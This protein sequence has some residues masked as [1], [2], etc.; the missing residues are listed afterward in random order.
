[1]LA[2]II[3]EHDRPIT[4]NVIN[5]VNI[6]TPRKAICEYREGERVSARCKGFGVPDGVIG[7][8]AEESQRKD[9]EDIL[10]GEEFE[11]LVKKI[12]DSSDDDV[13]MVTPE[14]PGVEN[15]PQTI[16]HQPA[17]ATGVEKIK[18]HRPKPR[19]PAEERKKN[20]EMLRKATAAAAAELELT[21]LG[22]DVE[23]HQLE[24]EAS[25]ETSTSSHLKRGLDTLIEEEME[26]SRT[27]DQCACTSRIQRLEQEVWHLNQKVL[28]QESNIS[29][30]WNQVQQ[31]QQT[32]ATP[33]HTAHVSGSGIPPV[34]MAPPD[35]VAPNEVPSAVEA[36]EETNPSNS[37]EDSATVGGFTDS[38][39]EWKSSHCSTY[40]KMSAVL[41]RT[42]FHEEEYVGR[43][44]AGG[45]N[46]PQVDPVK[47]QAIYR[48]V[49]KKF[50]GS[51]PV[52]IREKLR[53]LVKP[54]R[55]KNRRATPQK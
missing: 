29:W 18:L 21:E 50:P 45:G 20:E 42:L 51:T 36:P 26:I 35:L 22:R 30:L 52:M 39:L 14:T 33:V 55:V 41:F 43:T 16:E 17:A 44:L 53:D 11:S 9:L 4:G 49:A 15:D 32:R 54:C 47:M 7:K 5:M 34:E 19:R 12:L 24:N 3:W 2:L 31:L 38:Q 1:M 37:T 13:D 10:R 46:K 8:I 28:S 27:T 23:L 40:S 6:V 48:V 25:L